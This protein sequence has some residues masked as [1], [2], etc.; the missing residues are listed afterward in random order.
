MIFSY[1]FIEIGK[2]WISA[3]RVRAEGIVGALRLWRKRLPVD[4]PFIFRD[5]KLVWEIKG[6]AIKKRAFC[7]AL[8][9]FYSNL[10]TNINALVCI[11]EIA[12]VQ[13]G[14]VSGL[15]C[16]SSLLVKKVPRIAGVSL[17]LL[18]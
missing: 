7:E 13:Y 14:G 6:H 8:G 16:T 17:N 11:V 2:S 12:G 10:R 15:S 3:Q 1:V 9:F 18:K 4:R 5:E